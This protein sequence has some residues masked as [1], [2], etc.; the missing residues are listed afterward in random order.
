MKKTLQLLVLIIFGTVF[1]Y[2]TVNAALITKNENIFDEINSRKAVLFQKH[3]NNY[4]YKYIYT[5]P[6]YMVIEIAATSFIPYLDYKKTIDTSKPYELRDHIVDFLDVI[7]YDFVIFKDSFTGRTFYELRE[8]D[9]YGKAS[10]KYGWGTYFYNPNYTYD[11]MIEAPHPLFDS[12]TWLI[13]INCFTK[14]NG[15]AFFMAGAHRYNIEGDGHPSDVAHCKYSLFNANHIAW[16]RK[17]TTTYQIHGFSSKHHTDFPEYTDA[18]L[19]SGN[20]NVVS[21]S[22]IQLDHYLDLVSQDSNNL[23]HPEGVF[24]SYVYNELDSKNAINKE[25]N[26]NPLEKD[27]AKMYVNGKKFVSLGA[28]SNIEGQYT[29]DNINPGGFIHCEFGSYI[30]F[31]KERRDIIALRIAESINHE[32]H[33]SVYSDPEIYKMENDWKFNNNLNAEKMN[34]LPGSEYIND[35]QS[36]KSDVKYI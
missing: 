1:A 9:L 17:T 21:K 5:N 15:K 34:K 16:S 35:T 30:R 25:I 27:P 13:A 14:M 33:N 29:R 24:Y 26:R 3:D 23:S 28:T 22:I 36:D 11:V 12:N 20:K 2:C 7:N 32:I 10:Q 18:V 8:K 4:F 6:A 19:S 31:N